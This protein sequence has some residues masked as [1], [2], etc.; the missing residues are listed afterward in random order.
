MAVT[1][2][3][4]FVRP[5]GEKITLEYEI[6][7]GEPNFDFPGHICDGGGSGPEVMIVSAFREGGG[8]LRLLRWDPLHVR[9]LRRALQP[10]SPFR[11]F[12]MRW[13]LADDEEDAACEQIA[14]SHEFDDYYEPDIG[15]H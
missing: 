11:G 13:W 3:H 5:N 14:F 10:T 12:F 2:F 1:Y 6:E 9:L 15:W 7:P 4:D 8:D